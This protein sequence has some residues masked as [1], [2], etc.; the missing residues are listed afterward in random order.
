MQTVCKGGPQNLTDFGSGEI[1]QLELQTAL[2]GCKSNPCEVWWQGERDNPS[3]QETA[4]R[5]A[6]GQVCGVTLSFFKIELSQCSTLL[7]SPW[8]KLRLQ[9]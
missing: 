1:D 2:T 5:Q 3:P 8:P 4:L 9:G 7:K 6:S